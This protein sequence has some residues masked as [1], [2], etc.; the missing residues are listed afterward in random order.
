MLLSPSVWRGQG[1]QQ[2]WYS[3]PQGIRFEK[4]PRFQL[5]YVR[6]FSQEV[7]AN[8]LFYT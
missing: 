2:V 8:L 3:G 1:A 6:K 7:E 5:L 4:I